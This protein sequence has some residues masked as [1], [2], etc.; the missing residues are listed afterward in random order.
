M[1][2]DEAYAHLSGAQPSFPK[3]Y[4]PA[5]GL[6][7]GVGLI[8]RGLGYPFYDTAISEFAVAIG[9][10]YVVSHECDVAPENER[11]FNDMAVICPIIPLESLMRRYLA[12]RSPDQARAF[13]DSLSKRKIDRLAYIPTIADALPLGGV[14]YLNSLTH[15]HVSEF[16]KAGVER[17]C[18]VTAF[19][20][21]YMDSALSNALLKRPKAVPLPL[22][23]DYARWSSRPHR[24]IKQAAT[25]LILA[26]KEWRPFKER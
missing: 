20:L 9:Q 26:L 2:T 16:E 25:E 11:P 17:C 3:F 23:G 7:L 1:R 8:F 5:D 22:T 18:S 4:G 13:I 21:P 19:G 12:T 24:P 15:T 14:V 6:P 10:A